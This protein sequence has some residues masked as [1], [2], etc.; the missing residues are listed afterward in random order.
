MKKL[1]IAALSLFI[2]IASFAVPSV[3]LSSNT[4]TADTTKNLCGQAK[5]LFHGVCV[6]QDN[7]GTISIFD[8]RGSAVNPIG[9]IVSSSAVGNCL[10]YDVKTSSGL[11]YSKT[12]TT[13]ATFLY[14][15]G[16]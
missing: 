4:V 14:Q 9:V 16:Y 8:S 13:N 11:T 12:T 10:F 7:L 2:P 5:A 15:C 1:A 6:T 3:W